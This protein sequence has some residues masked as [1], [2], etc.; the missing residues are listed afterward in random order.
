M[1]GY[2]C[3]CVCVCVLERERGREERATGR[4]GETDRQRRGH[5][6]E[7][8]GVAGKCAVVMERER[9]DKWGARNTGSKGRLAARKTKISNISSLL[10]RPELRG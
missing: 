9:N 3:V 10:Q 6:D 4:E 2:A 5:E 8:E 1:C 7:G